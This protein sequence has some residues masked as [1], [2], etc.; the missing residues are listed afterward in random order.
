MEDNVLRLHLPVLDIHLIAA[1]DNR[2]VVTHTHQV[3]VPVGNILVSDTSCHVEHDDGT[4]PLDVV[5]VSQPPKLFLTRSVP[6]VE[7]YGS[8]ISVEH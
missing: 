1:E 6:H 4:L 5:A 2:D 3:T 8:A 7:T